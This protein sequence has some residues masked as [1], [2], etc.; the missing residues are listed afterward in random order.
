MNEFMDAVNITGWDVLMVPTVLMLL[1]IITGFVNAWS[2]KEISSSKLRKGISHKVGEI[3][4]IVVPVFLT[5]TIELPNTITT[6][7]VCYIIVMEIISIIENLEKLGIKTPKIITDKLE[8]MKG[9]ENEQKK[10]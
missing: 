6:F 2:K 8:E 3:V 4:M 1:D 9:N 10:V 5:K 7:I